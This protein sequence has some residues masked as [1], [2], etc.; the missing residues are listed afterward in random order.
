MTLAAITTSVIVM[1]RNR[2]QEK[3]LNR[4]F[5]T[6]IAVSCAF[7]FFQSS[8]VVNSGFLLA[9]Y[10]QRMLS[11]PSLKIHSETPKLRLLLNNYQGREFHCRFLLLYTQTHMPHAS[12]FFCVPMQ[13]TYTEIFT[14]IMPV[15]IIQE[16]FHITVV[17][18][19]ILL[20]KHHVYWWSR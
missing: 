1:L 18:I 4:I 5:I 8:G 12:L 16:P 3:I 20:Y 2:V 19:F 9:K 6:N 15:L 17:Y 11:H 14:L 7:V 10:A 13:T